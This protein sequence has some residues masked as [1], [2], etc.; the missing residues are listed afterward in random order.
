MAL[1]AEL[2][3][4]GAEIDE[5]DDG[6]KIMPRPLHA[7]AIDTYDDHRMAMSMA[8]VGLAVPG[9]LIRDPAC[10]AKTYPD[11]FTDLAALS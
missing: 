3:K 9:V 11:Y 6:L 4:F 7:A 10:V 8:L 2:R 1:A 5:R